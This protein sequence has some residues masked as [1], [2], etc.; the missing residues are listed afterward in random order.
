MTR[1]KPGDRVFASTGLKFGAYAEYTCLPEDGVVARMPTNLSYAQA[2]AVPS[3]G[4]AALA[5]LKKGN[6]QPQPAG[7][8]GRQKVLINGASGSIGTYAVQLAKHFGADV[9]GVTSTE[10][11]D[12][13]QHLGAAHVIDYTVEDF[14]HGAERYD[15]VFDAVGK[16][17]SGLSKAR[18]QQALRPSGTYLSIEMSYKE[19]AE[20]LVVL[21]ELIE[22]RAIEP[23]ID[24]TYPLEQVAEAHRYVEQK[25]KK[26]NVVIT[27]EPN[28]N[29]QQGTN[30][31]KP[32]EHVDGTGR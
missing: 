4:L 3:G 30:A 21:K 12:W 5:M 26:G 7:R 27:L 23:V 20:D 17:I 31:G 22:A 2:A 15:V 6:I 13:V 8:S 32:K 16:M 14:T 25:H 9:T 1:Y 29:A 11:L 28:I 18:C 19:R 24:R 10:N